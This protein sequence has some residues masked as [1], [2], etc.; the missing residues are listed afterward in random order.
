MSEI[1]KFLTPSEEEQLARI[2]NG[3][4]PHNKGW[5]FHAFVHNDKAYKCVGCGELKFY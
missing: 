3:L 2:L 1:E 4:C 5:M